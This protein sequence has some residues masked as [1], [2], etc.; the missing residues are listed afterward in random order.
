MCKQTSYNLFKNEITKKLFTYKSYMY[1]HLILGK[2]MDYS[3]LIEVFE[4]I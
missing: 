2:Q 4:T 1:I 3:C